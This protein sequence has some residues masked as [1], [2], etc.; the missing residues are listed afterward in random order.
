MI[1]FSHAGGN[2]LFLDHNNGF[3]SEQH[4]YGGDNAANVS[5][6]S[7]SINHNEITFDRYAFI[8]LAGC[9]CANP[10]SVEKV[11]LAESLAKIAP[12]TVYGA[13][14]QVNEEVIGGKGT[15]RIKTDG[16][17]IKMQRFIYPILK[18]GKFELEFQ[19]IKTDVGN[20][21]DPTKM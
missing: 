1:I 17:F 6:L 10:G 18:N 12:L 16:T 3:Y 7:Y 8:V 2:G 21:I 4:T 11:S 19:I 14:G 20:I 15:G 5:N 13:T 9:N